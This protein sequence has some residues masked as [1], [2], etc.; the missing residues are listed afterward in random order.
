MIQNDRSQ[1]FTAGSRPASP[2]QL[3]LLQRRSQRLQQLQASLLQQ[4]MH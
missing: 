1:G 2:R 3:Q 4:L